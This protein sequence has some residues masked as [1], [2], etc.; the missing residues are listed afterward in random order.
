[1]TSAGSFFFDVSTPHSNLR[2]IEAVRLP[3]TSGDN[4]AHNLQVSIEMYMDNI[5][6]YFV[7]YEMEFRT[8]HA[9]VC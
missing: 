3:G 6:E 7:L 1:M 8:W 5:C 9:W 2:H 4:F